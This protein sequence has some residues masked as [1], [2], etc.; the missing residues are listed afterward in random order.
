MWSG[1]KRSGIA[2]IM[3]IVVVTSFALLWVSP[4]THSTDQPQAGTTMFAP[5]IHSDQLSN[6]TINATI[7]DPSVSYSF[8]VSSSGTGS[9][10]G[11][12]Y[13]PYIGDWTSSAT[14]ANGVITISFSGLESIGIVP[15]LPGL[16]SITVDQ[17]QYQWPTYHVWWIFYAADGP[18][19]TTSYSFTQTN[20][21]VTVN[22]DWAYIAVVM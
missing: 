8:Y 6:N 14:V 16:S 5:S 17:T 7:I 21:Y 13:I 20:T 18:T 11:N 1:K 3:T 9:G 15:F 4:T 19:A 22:V 2:I 12:S 10:Y